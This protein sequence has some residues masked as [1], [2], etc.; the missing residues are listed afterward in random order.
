[1]R[2]NG[3]SRGLRNEQVEA[4]SVLRDVLI[5]EEGRPKQ[6]AHVVVGKSD[7]SAHGGHIIEAHVWPTVENDEC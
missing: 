7:A 5:D 4:L 3:P 2:S 1:M 6:R